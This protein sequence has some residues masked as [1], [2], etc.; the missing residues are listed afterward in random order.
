MKNAVMGC[1]KMTVT[2][3]TR[4]QPMSLRRLPRHLRGWQQFSLASF[5]HLP[6]LLLRVVTSY[7]SVSVRNSIR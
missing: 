2:I 6:S 5:R 7:L 3:V 1:Q 4:V